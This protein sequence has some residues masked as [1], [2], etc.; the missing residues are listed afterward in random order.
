[1][2]GPYLAP[3]RAPGTQGTGRVGSGLASHL[4]DAKE[5]SAPRAGGA[6]SVFSVVKLS[7][8]EDH[9]GIVGDER[10]R[11]VPAGVVD[12]VS[13]HGAAHAGLH[14]LTKAPLDVIGIVGIPL[15]RLQLQV[16]VLTT[17]LSAVLRGPA[18]PA[19]RHLP[20]S[21]LPVGLLL[22]PSKA[23][24]LRTAA[25]ALGGNLRSDALGSIG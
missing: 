9:L 23:F 4:R 22:V 6:L 8:F 24:L 15:L 1:M 12:H 16:P 19:L 21:R 7:C 13:P 2:V 11:V 25:F 10:R 3:V 20:G 5:L 14:L 18:A 17:K